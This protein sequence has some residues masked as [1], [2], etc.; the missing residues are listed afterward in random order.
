MANVTGL[1]LAGTLTMTAGV[2]ATDE[3]D[4]DHTIHYSAAA[5]STASSAS[6][7]APHYI[8]LELNINDNITHNV[9][10]DSYSLTEISYTK[11]QAATAGLTVTYNLPSVDKDISVGTYQVKLPNTPTTP[12][13]LPAAVFESGSNG[14]YN[15]VLDLSIKS[16]NTMEASVAATGTDTVITVGDDLKAAQKL[17]V[18]FTGSEGSISANDAEN[19]SVTITAANIN[20]NH[21]DFKTQADAVKAL[22]DGEAPVSNW[23]I[24]ATAINGDGSSSG[25]VNNELSLYSRED[26]NTAAAGETPNGPNAADSRGTNN[27]EVFAA[28]ALIVLSTPASYAMSIL[29]TDQDAEGGPATTTTELFSNATTNDVYAVLKQT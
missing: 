10:Y 23:T 28:G 19:L 16:N 21:A 18:D 24:T 9:D 3:I 27:N 13:D 12:A 1:E 25:N 4:R 15:I 8:Q 29:V 17:A 11:A 14:T 7:T 5:R 6:A 20:A 26:A 22:Y 2:A